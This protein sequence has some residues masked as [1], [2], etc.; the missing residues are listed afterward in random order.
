MLG[1]NPQKGVHVPKS[2]PP[3][4]PEFLAEVVRLVRQ[5][6]RTPDELAQTLGCSGQVIRNWLRQAD[7]E[8]RA[9]GAVSSRTNN[10]GWSQRCSVVAGH[11][12]DRG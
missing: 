2:H 5:G 12:L 7:L 3:Y 6:G 11:F 4:P 9:P 10:P 8:A 1:D